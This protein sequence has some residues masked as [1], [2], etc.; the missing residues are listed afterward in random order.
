MECCR[1][2]QGRNVCA[3]E[4]MKTTKH[5]VGSKTNKTLRRGSHVYLLYPS[6]VWTI[7]IGLRK[8]HQGQDGVLLAVH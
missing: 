1:Y 7:L 8:R 4:V 6:S 5:L 2:T 3:R